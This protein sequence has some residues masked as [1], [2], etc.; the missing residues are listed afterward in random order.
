[1]VHLEIF[2]CCMW[3]RKFDHNRH[4]HR[5]HRHHANV[6]DDFEEMIELEARAPVRH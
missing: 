1:M 2:I 3:L 6:D 5:R 4:H